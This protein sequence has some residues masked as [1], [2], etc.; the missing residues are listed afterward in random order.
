MPEVDRFRSFAERYIVERAG[1]FEK[2]KE[3]EEAW[4]AT[5]DAKTIYQNIAR[6]AR[7]AEP[8]GPSFAQQVGQQAQC[9]RV[10][11]PPTRPS[12]LQRAMSQ[13]SPWRNL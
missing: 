8:E 1:Q 7:D 10:D 5:L 2:G 4:Q 11:T 9:N 13:A 3:R 6:A 12:L